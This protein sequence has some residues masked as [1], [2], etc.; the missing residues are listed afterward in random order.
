MRRFSLASSSRTSVV[1][2]VCFATYLLVHGINLIPSGYNIDDWG[3]AA[4]GSDWG[5]LG[6]WG[7]EVFYRHGLGLSFSV[8]LQIAIAFLSFLAIS[9]LLVE[10]YCDTWSKSKKNLAV[11]AIFLVGTS[12]PYWLDSNNFSTAIGAYPFAAALGVLAFYLPVAARRSR[13]TLSVGACVLGG[14]LFGAALAIYQPAGLFGLVMA[15]AVL[16][17]PEMRSAGHFFKV[18]CLILVTIA[19]GLVLYRLQSQY[20]FILHPEKVPNELLSFAGVSLFLQKASQ[21]FSLYFYSLSAGQFAA[22]TPAYDWAMKLLVVALALATL[23][24]VKVLVGN[25]RYWEAARACVAVGACAVLPILGGWLFIEPDFPI[26][27]LS[28]IAFP[29]VFLIFVVLHETKSP[30][31][32]EDK[33]F[34]AA[35]IVSGTVF[36][37]GLM[38]SSVGWTKQQRSYERDLAVAY[39]VSGALAAYPPGLEIRLAGSR[40]YNDLVPIASVGQSIYENYWAKIFIFWELFRLSVQPVETSPVACQAAPKPGSIVRVDNVVYVCLE[41]FQD[42]S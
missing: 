5:V 32:V 34:A 26:R 16:F 7:L 9:F 15:G 31:A 29:V 12:H 24:L 8:T 10:T 20:Y 13:I 23:C 42:A 6:R 27:S 30:A 36:A 14:G 18:A 2:G 25:K 17:K 1:I 19:V 41:A 22:W 35:L 33:I 39:A 21:L 38:M 37:V 3:H 11:G 28:L 40:S 4:E